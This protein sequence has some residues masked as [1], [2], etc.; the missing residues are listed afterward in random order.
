M[1]MNRILVVGAGLAGSTVARTLAEDGYYVD[2]I[3]KRNHIAGNCYDYTNDYGIRVHKYGPHIFHTNNTEIFE[4]LSQYT[5]WIPYVH[6]VVCQLDNGRL[7]PFPVNK[8]TL[9]YVPND[10]ELITEIFYKRYTTKMWGT[11]NIDN[12][13][14]KRVAIRDDDDD[15]YFRDQKHQAIPKNG[16]S[17]MVANILDHKNINVMLDTVFDRQVKH[18]QHCFTSQPIDEYYDFCYGPLPYRSIKFHTVTLNIICMTKHPQI[19]FTHTGPYTRCIE[20]KNYPD[21]G[22]TNQYTTVTFEEP[23]SY[24]Q[25]NDERYYPIK[26]DANI[27]LY[28]RYKSI[29]NSKVTFIG[30]CGQYVYLDMDMAVASS[31]A[32]AKRY[33]HSV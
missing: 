32:V 13:I 28:K 6:K 15:R 8:T 4:W 11:E 12:S 3:D 20:W 25:N 9:K 16:Y 31:L 2:V 19:N 30:R 33:L 24:Q 14:I 17:E 23:C 21:H 26:N 7:V 29:P 18:Y 10:I 1:Q 22:T 27:E 5:Q